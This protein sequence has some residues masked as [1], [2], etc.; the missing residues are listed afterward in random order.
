MTDLCYNPTTQSVDIPLSNIIEMVT[1]LSEPNLLKCLQELT[2]V[3]NLEK[4]NS[5]TS[6]KS[7]TRVRKISSST[8]SLRTQTSSAKQATKNRKKGKFGE[9][10]KISLNV[11]KDVSHS[12]VV[13][14]RAHLSLTPQQINL[15]GPSLKLSPIPNFATCPTYWIKTLEGDYGQ[16]T[17]ASVMYNARGDGHCMFHAVTAGLYGQ[18][19][20]YPG[21]E[22]TYETP[23]EI[24]ASLK[25]TYHQ[26]HLFDQKDDYDAIVNGEQGDTLLVVKFANFLGYSC[27]LLDS[28]YGLMNFNF[29]YEQC[30]VIVHTGAHFKFLGD[31]KLNN[32]VVVGSPPQTPPPINDLVVVNS[33]PQTPPL[34]ASHNKLSFIEPS[35]IPGESQDFNIDDFLQDLSSIASSEYD[36]VSE[37]ENFSV[38]ENGDIIPPPIDFVD[39]P[40]IDIHQPP[41]N[42]DQVAVNF[43]STKVESKP[44]EKDRLR[45]DDLNN[46][47]NGYIPKCRT[48]KKKSF[49]PTNTQITV[50]DQKRIDDSYEKIKLKERYNKVAD[51]PKLQ[52]FP[53]HNVQVSIRVPIFDDKGKKIGEDVHI[54]DQRHVRKPMDIGGDSFLLNY[55]NFSP[56][57]Q[58]VK[59]VKAFN[60]L[61]YNSF[62]DI[63][64]KFPELKKYNKVD[65]ECLAH[66]LWKTFGKKKSVDLLVYIKSVVDN[67]F[68]GFDNKLFEP[69]EFMAIKQHTSLCALVITNNE[70]DAFRQIQL[71]PNLVNDISSV[72]KFL[73]EGIKTKLPGKHWYKKPLYWMGI[74]S[75]KRL[76]A[77]FRSDK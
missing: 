49:R 59:P 51:V 72:N 21:D 31:I 38:F 33:P 18:Q 12:P 35:L 8:S 29:D 9:I 32:S 77:S 70:L 25:K 1:S 45:K 26:S 75:H 2:K 67:Y 52:V 54:E 47:V 73:V 14:K 16:L 63:V 48:P 43:D 41:I 37:F 10:P 65:T 23:G 15:S 62:K 76:P 57:E 4:A 24:L 50:N 53:D 56:E 13:Q 55:P 28:N 27:L 36:N 22:I 11:P 71:S 7:I 64:A 30:V 20:D 66:V 60:P 44:K 6:T 40:L 58:V 19:I 17:D 3:L 68:A 39:E 46:L 34:V 42:I 69:M 61:E 74:K 5:M